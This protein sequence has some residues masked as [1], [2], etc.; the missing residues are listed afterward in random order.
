MFVFVFA[1]R[2]PIDKYPEY[3][4]FGLIVGPRGNS[5]K[6][7]EKETGCRIV[8]RGKGSAKEGKGR[9]DGKP[10][11]GEDEPLHVLIAAD[12]EE[13]L[14]KGVDEVRRLLTPVDDNSNEHKRK[15]LMELATINGTLRDN[16][17]CAYC[18]GSGH[19]QWQVSQI[20]INFSF[21]VTAKQSH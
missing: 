16:D 12:T 14:T 20:S 4:F 8:I 21:A 19:R 5:Q 7:L 6:R 17:F 13:C 2:I 15:Q 11:P 9:K 1:F 10:I 3:N 18:G